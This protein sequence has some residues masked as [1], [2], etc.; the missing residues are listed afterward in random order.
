MS[1]FHGED[2]RKKIRQ[3]VCSDSFS[4]SI[5]PLLVWKDQFLLIASL[6]LFVFYSLFNDHFRNRSFLRAYRSL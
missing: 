5:L 4:G 6:Y 1:S 2:R 3:D